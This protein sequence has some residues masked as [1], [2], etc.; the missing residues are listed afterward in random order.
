MISF[1]L[2]LADRIGLDEDDLVD[3]P[4]TR[5]DIADYPGLTNETVCRVV[6]ELKRAGLIATPNSRQIVLCEAESLQALADGEEEESAPWP[7]SRI[8]AA[9]IKRAFAAPVC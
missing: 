7:P 5:Q 3:V 9:P 1:L 4:M 8:E 6:T 2:S